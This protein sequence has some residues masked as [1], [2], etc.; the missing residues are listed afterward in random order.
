MGFREEA[1]AILENAPHLSDRQLADI[2]IER[3]SPTILPDTIRRRFG[4]LREEFGI[5]RENSMK[6]KILVLDIENAPVVAT[7]WNTRVWNTS[8]NKEQVLHDTFMISWVAKWLGDSAIHTGLLT[9]KEAK[10][11]ND[12]RIVK[13]L[14]NLMDDADIVIAHNADK[15]DIPMVNSRFLFH[16]LNP[17]SPYRTVDTLKVAKRQFKNTF[18]SLDYLATI[19]GYE[20]KKH[21]EMQLWIECMKGNEEKLQEM[22]DYNIQDVILLEQVY[23]DLRKWANSHPNVNLYQDTDFHCS[24]CGNGEL[25]QLHSDYATNTQ[26]YYAFRCKKCGG[27]SR[28]T[29]KNLMSTAR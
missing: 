11:K 17:P 28:K 3:Y 29:T 26:R 27:I 21:T 14:W 24:H 7:V 6:A 9:G 10:K 25:E 13:E 15:F 23:L 19:L 4:V 1:I 20:G 8:V 18:N 12:K 22:L 5:G 16:K 2:Y